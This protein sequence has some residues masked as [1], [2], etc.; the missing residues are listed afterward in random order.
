MTKAEEYQSLLINYD[1][2]DHEISQLKSVNAG[3][4]MTDE[5]LN[6]INDLKAKQQVLI[7][8]AAKLQE[9]QI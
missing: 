2:L 7:N 3:I 5:T 6:K 4:N 8:R 1:K 9:G